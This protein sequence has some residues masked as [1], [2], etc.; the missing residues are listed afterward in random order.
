MGKARGRA[1]FFFSIEINLRIPQRTHFCFQ[2]QPGLRERVHAE[3]F[4]RMDVP[5]LNPKG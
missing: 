3:T 1:F 4:R 2:L 5:G